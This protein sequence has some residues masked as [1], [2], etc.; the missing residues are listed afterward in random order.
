MKQLPASISR[1]ENVK[2]VQEDLRAAF[3][4]SMPQTQKAYLRILIEEIVLDGEKVTVR[5]KTQPAFT[6]SL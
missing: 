3:R 2:R 4:G 1:P 5:T 6:A